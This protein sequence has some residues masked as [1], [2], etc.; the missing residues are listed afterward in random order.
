[1][2]LQAQTATADPA[3]NVPAGPAWRST[4]LTKV[5]KYT[6]HLDSQL[7]T[8][9]LQNGASFVFGQNPL[10]AVVDDCLTYT[11][12]RGISRLEMM[13]AQ[14]SRVPVW[15]IRWA[16]PLTTA[17]PARWSDAETNFAQCNGY[18]L[19]PINTALE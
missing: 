3:N 9:R 19:M 12:L 14:D 4:L 1:M 8:M 15:E 13:R 10:C 11:T 6:E 2:A 18:S 5:E 7:M 16:G 17:G